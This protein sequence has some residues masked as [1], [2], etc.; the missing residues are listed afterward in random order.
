MLSTIDFLSRICILKTDWK[1]CLSLKF[2]FLFSGCLERL[3]ATHQAISS[4]CLCNTIVRN[5]APV[6]IAPI[7]SFFLRSQN[8]ISPERLQNYRAD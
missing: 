6:E 3:F 4:D 5:E 1:V 7:L 8:F 2:S